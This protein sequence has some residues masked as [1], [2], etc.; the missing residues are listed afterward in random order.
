MFVQ[1]AGEQT[2]LEASALSLEGMSSEAPG[3]RKPAGPPVR[4][5]R[6]GRGGEGTE[7]Y[8]GSPCLPRRFGTFQRSRAELFLSPDPAT[9]N[10][11]ISLPKCVFLL[12][13]GMALG[14]LAV[15]TPR[16]RRNRQREKARGSRCLWLIFPI[17]STM[18]HVAGKSPMSRGPVLPL[19]L[20]LLGV[21]GE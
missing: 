20:A 5:E 2:H 6:E 11:L 18:V 12:T 9:P 8:P 15:G 16:T 21:V 17:V 10:T 1:K 19:Y 3:P 13:V 4:P 7:S 14:I